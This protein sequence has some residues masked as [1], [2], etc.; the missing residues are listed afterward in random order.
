MKLRLK[1]KTITVFKNSKQDENRW[2]KMIVVE[3]VSH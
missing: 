2:F 3:Y 1:M